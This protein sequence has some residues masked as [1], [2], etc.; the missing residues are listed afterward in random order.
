M[1]IPVVLI[2]HY[3][4]FPAA[5]GYGLRM[6]I[7][8]VQMFRDDGSGVVIGKLTVPSAA[9]IANFPLLR[10]RRYVLA[11]AGRVFVASAKR[12]NRIDLAKRLAST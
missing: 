11:R 1:K 4:V 9:I 7:E 12:S 6:S 5:M 8:T 3:L 2:A 10:D